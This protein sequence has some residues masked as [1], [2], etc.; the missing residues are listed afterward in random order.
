VAQNDKKGTAVAVVSPGNAVAIRPVKIMSD[1]GSQLEIS[2]G[3]SSS[4]RIV[5]GPADGI[6]A[7]DKVRVSTPHWGKSL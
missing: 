2:S 4:D 1:L 7:G 5:D 3:L 6:Q